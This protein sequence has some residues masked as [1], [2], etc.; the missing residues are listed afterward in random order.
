MCR[1]VSRLLPIALVVCCLV[2]ASCGG[3]AASKDS[4][5]PS[6]TVGPPP[7]ATAAATATP[8]STPTPKGP[9]IVDRLPTQAPS[10]VPAGLAGCVG[11]RT[12]VPQSIALAG[13]A[14]PSMLT[15]YVP[16]T[17]TVKADGSNL[18]YIRDLQVEQTGAGTTSH[19]VWSPDGTKIAYI[20]GPEP[21]S[22]DVMDLATG[23]VIK[24][25]S[26]ISL[27]AVNWDPLGKFVGVFGKKDPDSPEDYYLVPIDGGAWTRVDNDDPR[28]PE[29]SPNGQCMNY[30]TGAETRILA[31]DGTLLATVPKTEGGVWSPDGSQLAL[32][33]QP[34][35]CLWKIGGDQQPQ[36]L[37]NGLPLGWTPDGDSVLTIAWSSGGQR[38][39]MLSLS[40]APVV[41]LGTASDAS[42]SPDGSNVAF[43]RDGNVYVVSALG[44]EPVQIT[45]STLPFM[46]EPRWSPDSSTIMFSF[47]PQSETFIAGSDGSGPQPLLAGGGAIW[48]PDGGK[49]FFGAGWSGTGASGS[50]YVADVA[51][52]TVRRL[53]DYFY[54]DAIGP[55]RVWASSEWSPDGRYVTFD[56]DGY[57]SAPGG[58]FVAA[59]DGSEAPRNVSCG[60][61]PSWSADGRE[62][63]CTGWEGPPANSC[64]LYLAPVSGGEP[65][66]LTAGE[67]AVWSPRGDLIAFA[68]SDEVHVIS[69]DGAGDRVVIGGSAAGTP[70]ILRWSRDGRMLAVSFATPTNV[71]STYAIDIDTGGQATYLSDG[72]VESWSPDGQQVAVSKFD[73]EQRRFVTYLVNADGSGERFFV[74]GDGVD[75]SPDGS[76]ILF[77][78]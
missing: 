52:G 16:G 3:T 36:N 45:D 54:S 29:W 78:R 9:I 11:G 21:L 65:K 70:I 75:W 59:A 46:V 44:G 28:L 14:P 8:V 18:Q 51:A 76:K 24:L 23:R 43:I 60:V 19:V 53:A 33:C 61:A 37:G 20:S 77:S 39:N 58:T 2:A 71:W 17:Y 73:E 32:N 55:C 67:R 49:I 41:D 48:S 50:F 12:T 38:L 15:G 7:S 27:Y 63:V 34:D 25:G 47:A 10:P 56:S 6:P 74:D 69:P 35:V 31:R 68:A 26:S 64:G 5:I 66:L 62:L 30:G 13:E 1:G 72:E 57:G 42:L 22:L 4:D 40:G